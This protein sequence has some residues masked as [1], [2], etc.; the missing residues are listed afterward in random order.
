MKVRLL[1]VT[2]Y[3]FIFRFINSL[4]SYINVDKEL[5]PIES[6]GLNKHKPSL[7]RY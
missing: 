1:I 3:D 7:P 2:K 4:I 5:T 6:S